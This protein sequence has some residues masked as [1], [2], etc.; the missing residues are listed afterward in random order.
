MSAPPCIVYVW[1]G[2]GSAPA[3]TGQGL[4]IASE[5]IARSFGVFGSL[6]DEFDDALIALP[7]PAE[8]DDAK[9]MVDLIVALRASSG[10]ECPICYEALGDNHLRTGCCNQPMHFSCLYRALARTPTCPLC[11]QAGAE[12]AAPGP[13]GPSPLPVDADHFLRFYTAAHQLDCSYIVDICAKHLADR[14]RGK[15]VEEL[16]CEFGACDEADVLCDDLG[17]LAVR[18][19]PHSAAVTLCEK[20]RASRRTCRAMSWRTA[21]RL[22]DEDLR[23]ELDFQLVSPVR[24]DA[25]FAARALVGERGAHAAEALH[26][27]LEEFAPGGLVRDAGDL[28]ACIEL[29]ALVDEHFGPWIVPEY[30]AQVVVRPVIMHVQARLEARNQPL[31]VRNVVHIKAGPGCCK[32]TTGRALVK[33]LGEATAHHYA[34]DASCRTFLLEV[35]KARTRL[36][37]VTIVDPAAPGAVRPVGGFDATEVARVMGELNA[38][39]A[40]NYGAGAARKAAMKPS[41]DRMRDSS[42]GGA[43]P[44]GF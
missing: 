23:D 18:A 19:M 33:W 24:A 6:L 32:T 34:D 2:E 13:R 14:F 11:R 37:Q 29:R 5:A 43:S 39:P 35:Y 15:T 44:G 7:C 38:D 20:F 28:L 1:R 26:R 3:R 25:V 31:G 17:R 9:L 41:R 12:R 40:R 36:A 21:A 42:A 22:L 8:E 27:A 16:V 4:V 10:V 30:A